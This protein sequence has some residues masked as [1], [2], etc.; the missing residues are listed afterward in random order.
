M[1]SY[2]VI[3]PNRFEDI[4]QPLIKSL[5]IYEQELS[6]VIIIADGHD[7]NYGYKMIKTKGNF[8]YSKAINLGIKAADPDDVILLNDD[9]RLTEFD[10]FKTL[11]RVTYSKPRIGIL[12]P[13]VDGG[14]GNI[15]MRIAKPELWENKPLGIKYCT[16]LRGPD[17]VTFACVYIKRSLLNLIGLMDE[18]FIYYGFDD[19]DFCIRTV[20][21]NWKIAITNKT[22][23]Q[24][25][26]GG[27][28]FIRGKNWNSSYM[29]NRIGGTVKNLNYLMTKHPTVFEDN[30]KFEQTNG[31]SN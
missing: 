4:I 13:L 3:I 16:G 21:A 23:V 2:T 5:R 7:R 27:S 14:C 9:V 1:N 24:H 31:P 11:Q 28:K 18:N 19:A 29:R 20:Q 22:Q 17:R 12:S 15:Y 25:G 6:K 26:E 8:I 10:T 30:S